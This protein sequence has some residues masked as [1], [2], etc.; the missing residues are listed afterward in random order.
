MVAVEDG[1]LYRTALEQALKVDIPIVA[2]RNPIANMLEFSSLRGNGSRRD[3]VM[4]A[5]GR[6]GRETVAK[7]LFTSGLNGNAEGRDQHSWHALRE[8]ADETPVSSSSG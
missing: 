5:V 2:L 6:T 8:R 4:T 1:E 3:A 7:Y